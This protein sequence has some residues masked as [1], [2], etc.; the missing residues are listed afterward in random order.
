MNEGL[1]L[2]WAE[3]TYSHG[4]P[5]HR[6]R[7]RTERIDVPNQ[8][9]GN[10]KCNAAQDEADLFDHGVLRS[11]SRWQIRTL[12]FPTSGLS[13]ACRRD[14]GTVVQQQGAEEL[15]PTEG[16]G[17]ASRVRVDSGLG[18]HA[19]Q[20]AMQAPLLQMAAQSLGWGCACVEHHVGKYTQLRRRG[21][22]RAQARR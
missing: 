16:V 20:L 7:P 5:R 22:D 9:P 10:D 4:E 17:P 15:H 13:E 14:R 18:K 1:Q 19:P 3:E 12:P 2:D 21:R 11:R 6:S 8:P